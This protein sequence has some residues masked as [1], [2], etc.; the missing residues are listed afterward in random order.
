[1]IRIKNITIKNFM[2][3]GNCTQAI[4]FQDAGLTLV[5]GNNLD[6][7][8]DG[9]RNG[10]G[11]AQPL[12]SKIKT[13]SGWT[14]MKDINIGDIVSTPDGENAN[15]IGTYPQG[16]LDIYE[17]VFADGR[18]THACGNHLWN[19]KSHS[20]RNNQQYKTMSTNDLLDHT[21]KYKNYTNRSGTYLYIPFLS[22]DNSD[23]IDLP[24]QPYFLGAMLGDGSF[25]KNG[26]GFSNA[27]QEIIDRVALTAPS[28]VL[29]HKKPSHKIYDYGFKLKTRTRFS[30]FTTLLKE[31]KL[32]GTLSHT[33][34]VPDIFKM[35]SK[36]QKIELIQGLMDTDGF[37]GTN[38]AYNYTTVSKQLALDVQ[39]LIRSIGGS[40]IIKASV[41]N[42]YTNNYGV[43]KACKDAYTVCITYHSPKDLVSVTRKRDRMPGETYQYKNKGLR[44]DS[45]S[46]IGRSDAKCIMID[47]PDHL[48]ITDNYVVT[49]NTTMINALSY[50]L[51][52]SALSAIKR[53]NLINKTNNKGMLVTVEFEVNGVHYRIERGRSPNVLKFLVNN[54]DAIEETDEGQG[55]G[56][57]TQHE[58]ERVFGMNHLMFKHLIA[59]NTY[60]EPFLALRANDQREIIENLLGITML[61]E[62][63]VVLKELNKTTKDQIKEEEYRIK[64]VE[65]ANEQIKK[66][67]EDLKRRHRVWAKKKQESIQELEHMVN[68]L[69]I[70]D[71]KAEISQHKALDAYKKSSLELA[72]YNKALAGF[73]SDMIREKRTLAQ[74]EQDLKAAQDHKCYACGH[75]LHDDDTLQ[76]IER[77][78]ATVA[79]ASLVIQS[80][81]EAIREI[82]EAIEGITLPACI[83]HTK[84][85][86]AQEAYEQQ[87]QL[88]TLKSKLDDATN[89]ED[90]YSDQV[91]S[92]EEG[93]LRPIEWVTMNNLHNLRE[94]QEFLLKLLTNK[95]S[96]IRKR[97]IEQNLQ[98]LNSRLNY[99]LNKLGLPHEVVFQSDLNVEITE[100]GRELDFDNL[101]RGERNRLI[102]GLSWAFRDVHESTNSP[103]DFMAIDELIDNG[104]DSNGV[105]SA[106]LVLKKMHRDR[107]KNIF[108]ISHRDELIGRVNNTLYVVKEN[109]FTSFSH[110]QE[111]DI[112]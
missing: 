89:A 38:G 40:A 79:D 83:P 19:V 108:L 13:P 37:V 22:H 42:T 62:K 9:S 105:E 78:S 44:I 80:A 75:E 101:S 82:V 5:L 66:S 63:A 60:N 72:D 46:Y 30:P 39:D 36:A 11:K 56:R 85:A 26:V 96:F 3:C 52:G 112:E 99:Y 8:G 73:E 100:L 10:V 61:S 47:H 50:A 17:F 103:I 2:S 54:L 81:Q 111:F 28:C 27:D 12:Y 18:K 67:I 74:A 70:L 98:Y 84:Y 20:F 104:L 57:L 97:I 88:A 51:Y 55:E 64:G 102:L 6:L 58:I 94:H 24:M 93:G 14:T 77:K 106:L 43:V 90:P 87:S 21:E 65:N 29:L 34:F 71:I 95:D 4:N 16:E 91:K 53:N 109:G 25:S 35:A 76:I 69:E 86:T 23:A 48:Y 41:N 92:L 59:L 32:F 7:G 49:H 107:E 68:E 31:L 33:K 15:V 1:M 45:I 110:D